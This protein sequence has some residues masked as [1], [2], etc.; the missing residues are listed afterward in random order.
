MRVW[1]QIDGRWTPGEQG[2]G[3]RWFD[4]CRADDAALRDL[5]ARFGLHPLAIEDCLS[6]YLHTPK[7]EDFGGHLF[8]ILADMV[9]GTDGPEL[10]ELDVFLGPDFL[11]TYHDRTDGPPAIG[12]LAAALE[13]GLAIRPGVSGLFYEVADR[14]VD[15]M[16]P[17][18]AVMAQELD[19]V[20]EDLLS[21][22]GLGK[23]QRR[24]VRQRMLAGRIRRV[25]TPEIQVMMRFGRGEFGLVE[26][27]NRPYFRDVY[28]HLLRVDIA[29][30]GLRE[31]TE[32]ALSMHLSALNNRLN[33]VMKVLAIV[34]A[35]ALP[36]TVITGVFGTNFDNVPGLHSN[37]GFALMMASILGVAGGMAMFFR[38]RGWF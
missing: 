1:S 21:K 13:L 31:D 32:V 34:S 2:P 8:L 36:G 14:T 18:V 22:G 28:D 24:V 11:V 25:L 33:E 3:V 17:R 29:L 4:L 37:W 12:A 6:P 27:S 10:E 26:D 35:L 7:V 5:A 16:I 30:D 19:E 9:D 20:E 38:R 15:A 23:S